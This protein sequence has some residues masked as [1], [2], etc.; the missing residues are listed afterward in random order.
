MVMLANNKTFAQVG[1][2][3]QLFLGDNTDTFT[4]WLQTVVSNPALLQKKS[5][6]GGEGGGDGGERCGEG[7]GGGREGGGEERCGGGEERSNNG[8]GEDRRVSG[9]AGRGDGQ[10]L[11]QGAGEVD[12][13]QRGGRKER[14]DG[15]ARRS[16]EGMYTLCALL[17]ML[18]LAVNEILLKSCQTML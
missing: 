14:D 11:E 4:S 18:M 6:E 15:G 12:R 9:G 2:D 5:G 17:S 3:L 16:R 7:G 10:K 13:E 8:G 1:E